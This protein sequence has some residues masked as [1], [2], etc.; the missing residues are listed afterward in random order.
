MPQDILKTLF[1]KV[2]VQIVFLYGNYLFISRLEE[3]I[4]PEVGD[5]TK[6]KL[7]SER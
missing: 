5:F 4:E 1:Y 2:N 3:A 6:L 7:G